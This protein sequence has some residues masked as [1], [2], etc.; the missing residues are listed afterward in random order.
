MIRQPPTAVPAE[1]AGGG[2]R[3]ITHDGT[4]DAGDDPSEK[5]ASVMMPIVFWASFEPWANAI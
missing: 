3:T 2:P 5:S 1:R 4:A